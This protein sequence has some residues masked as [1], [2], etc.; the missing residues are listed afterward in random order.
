MPR[1]GTAPL[2]SQNDASNEAEAIRKL[3]GIVIMIKRPG[4]KPAKFSW[5]KLGEFLYDKLGIMWG[6]HP[7]ERIDLIKPDYIINNDASI[8]QLQLDLGAAILDWEEG[9]RSPGTKRVQYGL[10]TLALGRI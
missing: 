2:P 9:G 1:T 7:S 8:E 10:A 6:V 3:G 5:G 4:T